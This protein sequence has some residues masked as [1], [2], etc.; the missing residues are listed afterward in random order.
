MSLELKS[1]KRHLQARGVRQRKVETGYVGMQEMQLL[2]QILL[3]G[4]SKTM[5]SWVSTVCPLC[6]ID[7]QA[8]F[9]RV[10]LP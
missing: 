2:D 6:M 5:F 8:H 10:R 3:L 7:N 9:C 4:S 1:G